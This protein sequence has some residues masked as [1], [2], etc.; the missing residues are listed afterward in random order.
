MKCATEIIIGFQRNGSIGQSE[1][2]SN[3][4]CT[5]DFLNVVQQVM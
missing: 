5:V 1:V 2:L 3:R 4:Q